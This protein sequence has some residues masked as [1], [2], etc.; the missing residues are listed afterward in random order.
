M[1]RTDQDMPTASLT[2]VAQLM[3]HE[4]HTG[5]PS[6]TVLEAA[7]M[8]TAGSVGSTLVMDGGRLVGIFTER[9]VVKALSQAPDAL[10]DPIGRWMT[11]DPQTISPDGLPEE[12][13][14]R[15]ITGGFRHLPVIDGGKV[16]GM[17]SIRDLARGSL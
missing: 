8:M 4:L 9:D 13:L 2:T 1:D 14:R 7:T 11:P 10:R 15:M 3:D 6:T 17:L 16:V 5:S 12:A